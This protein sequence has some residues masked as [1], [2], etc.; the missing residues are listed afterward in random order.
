MDNCIFCKIVKGEIPSFKIYEDE[1]FL[2]FM[3][4]FPRAKGH[5]LVIPKD[6]HRWVYDV[7]NFGLYWEVARN[8]AQKI[9][10]Q[11]GAEFISFLTM[12][13][14]VPHA[15]IHILPN[16]EGVKFGE[17]K[18]ISKEEIAHIAEQVNNNF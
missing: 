12:G 18:S 14:E 10:Q 5:S 15:H 2:A 7:P 6:H 17:V 9:Q 8:V 13:E 16:G 4:V 3:D 1:D 11:V